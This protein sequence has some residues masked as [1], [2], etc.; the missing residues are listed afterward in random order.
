M[1]T[2]DSHSNFDQVYIAYKTRIF[3]HLYSMVGDRE[4][5]NDLTQD[6]FLKA[7]RA[8][9]GKDPDRD[10]SAWLYVIATNTAIDAIRRRK[11]ISWYRWDDLTETSADST[12]DDPQEHYVGAE[13]VHATLT[14]MP[15]RYRKALRLGIL[16]GYTNEEVA[17]ALGYSEG[18]GR[19]LLL[20]ARKSFREHYH[21]ALQR[22]T[23]VFPQERAE[24][25]P[26]GDALKQEHAS[27]HVTV[28]HAP[29]MFIRA[30][31]ET[32][33]NTLQEWATLPLSEDDGFIG[34]HEGR[35]IAYLQWHAHPERDGTFVI[36]R[37]ETHPSF[38]GF[39]Y[40]RHMVSF[41]QDRMKAQAIIACCVQWD[42]VEFW[43]KLGFDPDGFGAGDEGYDA[44][45]YEWRR[46]CSQPKDDETSETQFG[47]DIDVERTLEQ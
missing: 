31:R 2:P 36:T 16:E 17:K 43:E 37:V 38:R 35:F 45:S 18:G 32:D 34:M 29:E 26:M 20:R 7:F 44:G 10:I 19:M 14:C 13:L 28:R 11:R 15:E 42:A 23:G 33:W 8:L 22:E 24:T 39:G 6:T 12:D 41:F 25:P 9:P 3:R 47:E 46:L 1:T 4:Q 40:G 30:G 21:L 5:A 27:H